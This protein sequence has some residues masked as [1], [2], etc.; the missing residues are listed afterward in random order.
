MCKIFGIWDNGG[1]SVDRY[2]V[3]TTNGDMIGFSTDPFYP[4]G[5]N[6]YVGKYY[7]EVCETISDRPIQEEDFSHLG[8]EL[9]YEDLP[10][11]V[12]EAIAQRLEH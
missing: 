12:Q 3:V 4:P 10:E 9:Q 11:Q 8:K 5:F 6:Q 1:V 7:N 2:T